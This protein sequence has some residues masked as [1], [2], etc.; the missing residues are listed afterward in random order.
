MK[1]LIA[2]FSSFSLWAQA[3]VIMQDMAYKGG[4][5]EFSGYAVYDT[6][7]KEERPGILMVHDWLGVTDKA[8]QQ[9]RRLAALGYQVFAVDIYGK[10][11]RPD[12][13]TAGQEAGKYKTDRDLFRERLKLGLEQ[14]KKLPHVNKKKIA[15]VGYCFGGTGVIELAR[16][17]ADIKAA[18]SFHGGLDSPTPADGKKIKARILALHGADDPFVSAADLTAFE[19]EMRSH[20]VDWQLV[21]YGNSVH[22]FTDQTAGTDN[23]KGAAYNKLADE[24][25]WLAMD[26]FLKTTFN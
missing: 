1:F 22:S 25:S 24:R 7:A 23:S 14:L 13:K 18:V 6:D 16:T 20:R 12:Y 21:K 15:A 2:L 5:N 26:N 17:G 10:D 8:R 11:I 19:S 9:A 4:K 3:E